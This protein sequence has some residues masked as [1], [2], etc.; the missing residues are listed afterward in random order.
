MITLYNSLTK[1]KEVFTPLKAGQ[2]SIYSCGPTVYDHAHIGNLRS[3]LFAD[4]LQRTLR[5]IEDLKVMWVMN[6][7]DVDDKMIVR[8]VRDYPDDPPMVALGKLADK[9]TDLFITDLEEV[10]IHRTDL[11]KLPRATDHIESMQKLIRQLMSDSIAYESHGSVYF[12]LSKYQASGKEYGVLI[13]IHFEGQSRVI[14]DQD[15]KE[16]VGDF[17]LWK[18]AKDGEPSWQFSLDG[19]QLPGRP[20]W[21]IECSAMSTDYLGKPFDIHTG[22]IDMKFPHHTNEIAQ[23]GG[24]LARYFMYNEFLNISGEKMSKSVGN[25][26]KLAD[27]GDAMAFRLLVLSAHY[28]TKMDFSLESVAAARQRLDNLRDFVRKNQYATELVDNSEV[29]DDFRRSFTA[30]LRDDLNTPQAFAALAALE[31][32][33]LRVTGGLEA[34]VWADRVLGLGLISKTQPF[35]DQELALQQLRAE[36]RLNSDY[37]A[38][39]RLRD[40]LAKFGVEVEDLGTGSQYWRSI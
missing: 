37:V 19:K 38:S 11:A 8:A 6:I 10:G 2:A 34:V 28:R 21:H 23:S 25:F 29:I 22:G 33:G 40:E 27:I 17:A 30:A 7:T 18:A 24:D 9:F 14:D 35:S 13:D 15:Q 1:Q 31:R 5:H 26:Y 3:Y 32:D 12:S 39:D 4:L 36:A 20:G 16:G